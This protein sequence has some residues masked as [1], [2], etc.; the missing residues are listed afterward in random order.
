MYAA[1]TPTGLVVSEKVLMAF[2]GATGS[3]PAKTTP[4]GPARISS[5]CDASSGPAARL[6][7]VFFTTP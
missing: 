2:A 3:A 5:S 7:S 6:K 1:F 4:V